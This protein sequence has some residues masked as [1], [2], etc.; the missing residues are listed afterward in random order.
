MKPKPGGLHPPPPYHSGLAV[1]V[2]PAAA[3]EDGGPGLV[4][5]EAETTGLVMREERPAGPAGRRRIGLRRILIFVIVIVIAMPEERPAGPAGLRRILIF[6]IV[7]VIVIV[8]A[9]VIVFL[10]SPLVLP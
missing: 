10:S 5:V 8:I 4:E 3:A 7:I 1:V 6:V 2:A 9:I